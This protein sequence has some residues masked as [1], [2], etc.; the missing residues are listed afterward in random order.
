MLYYSPLGFPLLLDL[1]PPSP[2]TCPILHLTVQY[3]ASSFLGPFSFFI[4]ALPFASIDFLPSHSDTLSI[5]FLVFLYTHFPPDF[6]ICHLPSESIRVTSRQK[7]EQGFHDFYGASNVF[8][9]IWPS[10]NLSR[11]FWRHVFSK[12]KNF[13]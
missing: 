13:T 12:I 5:V 10:R 9:R 2:L 11:E 8:Y 6:P 3:M 7:S 1:A 4:L